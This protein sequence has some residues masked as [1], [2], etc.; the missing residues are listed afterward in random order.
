MFSRPPSTNRI[1][2][3]E[4]QR[5]AVRGVFGEEQEEEPNEGHSQEGMKQW[6]QDLAVE[7]E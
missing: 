7:E 1:I 4:P 2:I 3:A 6:V 5:E